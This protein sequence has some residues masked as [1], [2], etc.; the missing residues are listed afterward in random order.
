LEEFFRSKHAKTRIKRAETRLNPTEPYQI[1]SQLQKQNTA[2]IKLSPNQAYSKPL[3]KPDCT[4]IEEKTS[5]KKL[6]LPKAELLPSFKPLKV[7]NLEY[8]SAV[9][10]RQ[11][12]ISHLKI[13]S[14]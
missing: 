4:K 14:K 7:K 8:L 1:P 2:F 5:L 9:I 3:P 10:L 13:N 6:N 12:R 11:I